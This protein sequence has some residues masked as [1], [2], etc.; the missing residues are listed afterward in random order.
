MNYS[1]FLQTVLDIAEEMLVA[2]AE[3]NR[4]EDSIV[5]MCAA[6]GCDPTRVNVFIITSNIQ[7]TFEDPEGNIITQ[8]RQVIRSDSNYERIDRLNDLSRYICSYKPDRE[9]IKRRYD[10]VMSKPKYSPFIRYLSAITVA[11]GFAVFFDGT[12]IDGLSSAL[13]GMVIMFFLI[14]LGKYGRN[15][16]ALIFTTS[17]V[18]GTVSIT[19]SALGLGAVDKIAIGSIMLLIP[20]IAMTNSI[21]DML[22]GDVASGMIRLVNSIL[23]ALFIAFGFAIPLA[24]IRQ[25]QNVLPIELFPN[26]LSIA[27]RSGDFRIAVQISAAFIGCVGF[28][29]YYNL[30]KNHVVYA[31]V[32][33]TLT[34]G[35]YLFLSSIFKNDHFITNLLAAIF[36]A[37]YAEIMAKTKK[38]PATVFLAPAAVTLIPGS[39]LYSTMRFI[40]EDEEKYAA[41]F[42]KIALEV[43]LAISLGFLVVVIV[44]RYYSEYV[45]KHV[46][47]KKNK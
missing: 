2:G 44:Y 47:D 29:L 16:I 39:A 9:E 37:V 20:G 34:W 4:V 10:E 11:G 7:V 43:A 8:I 41:Y 13:V 26:V 46:T 45:K 6:Y 5:R 33:G 42:G 27:A 1:K 38:A 12:F 22:I 14:H 17:L 3:V 15:Q 23:T 24:F 18:A 25:L 32:G 36:A 21:R 19:L 31:A 28:S 35:I 40:I 30:K